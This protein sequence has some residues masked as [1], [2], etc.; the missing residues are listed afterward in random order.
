[1]AATPPST[2][3]PWEG[4][5]ERADRFLFAGIIFSGLYALALLPAVPALI[6]THPVLLEIFRGSP[7]RSSPGCPAR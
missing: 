2:P 4:T 3:F 6:G 1:M 7:S 5:A